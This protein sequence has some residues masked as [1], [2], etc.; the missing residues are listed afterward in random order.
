MDLTYRAEDFT[1]AIPV[2]D[3]IERFPDAERFAACCREC[4]NYNRSWCCPPFDFDVP[5]AP[6][7]FFVA[8]TFFIFYNFSC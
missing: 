7:A 6:G 1:R 2:A 8:I 5:I 3:Y 4:G